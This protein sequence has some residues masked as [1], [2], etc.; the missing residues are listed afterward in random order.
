M[1]APLKKNKKAGQPQ[2]G[3]PAFSFKDLFQFSKPEIDAAFKDA[4]RISGTKEFTLLQSPTDRDYG[5]ML[6][7]ISRKVGKAHDRN[8]LRRRLKA[9]F[10]ENELYKQKS[11]FILLTRLGAININFKALQQF[12]TN[13]IQQS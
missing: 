2:K 10:Y 1:N 7:I 4:Q 11:T 6:I 8:L 3:S 13:S 5:K 12:L 9:I